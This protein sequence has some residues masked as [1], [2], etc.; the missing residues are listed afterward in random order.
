MPLY[1]Y[2]K[3][4]S[5]ICISNQTISCHCSRT[6][7]VRNNGRINDELSIVS[8]IIKLSFY[9]NLCMYQQYAYNL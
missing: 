8:K 6:H 3:V 5:V 4:I 7:W 9:I 1:Y 2:I